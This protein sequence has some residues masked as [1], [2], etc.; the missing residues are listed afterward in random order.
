M[1]LKNIALQARPSRRPAFARR[2]RERFDGVHRRY[3]NL[4][5]ARSLPASPSGFRMVQAVGGQGE[6]EK[7][8]AKHDGGAR[9]DFVRA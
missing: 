6:G 2:G 1:S 8:S 3:I 4:R 5:S 9:A 7:R